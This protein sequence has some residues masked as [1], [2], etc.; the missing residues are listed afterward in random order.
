MIKVD[1]VDI[2]LKGSEK[3]IV[4]DFAILI[5]RLKSIFGKEKYNKIYKFLLNEIEEFEREMAENTT[6]K[7]HEI[8]GTNKNE[9]LKQLEDLHAPDFV[10]KF[11]ISQLEV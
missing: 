11:I 5:R 9:I 2:T 1:G 4:S 6:I 10:K 7:I 8:K 3:E